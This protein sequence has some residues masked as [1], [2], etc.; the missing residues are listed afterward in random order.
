MSKA[1]LL[2]PSAQRLLGRSGGTIR[3]EANIRIPSYANV[4]LGA[5]DIEDIMT[6]D[7]HHKY[8]KTMLGRYGQADRKG[9]VNCWTR[10]RLST[11]RI[12]SLIR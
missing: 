7:K 3:T 1:G 10:R 8:L 2:A 5:M 9:K 11:R 6:I 4:A 12:T